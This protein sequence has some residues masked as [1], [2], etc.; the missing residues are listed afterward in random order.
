LRFKKR[1]AWSTYSP[2]TRRLPIEPT[3]IGGGRG[4]LIIL[5]IKKPQHVTY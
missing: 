4:L 1:A 3:T 2:M 5:A